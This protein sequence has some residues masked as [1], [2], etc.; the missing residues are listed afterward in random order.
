MVGVGVA[1]NFVAEKES[2]KLMQLSKVDGELKV[3]I[4]HQKEPH[5]PSA[6][7][8]TRVEAT[9]VAEQSPMSEQSSSVK[10]DHEPGSEIKLQK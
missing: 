8:G 1:V 5:A 6:E 10:L 4:K 9:V 7:L 3:E 2:Q